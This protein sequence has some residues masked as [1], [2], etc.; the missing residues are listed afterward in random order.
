MAKVKVNHADVHSR[1]KPCIDI[2]HFAALKSRFGKEKFD[3]IVTSFRDELMKS[4]TLLNQISHEC[5]ID[6]IERQLHAIYGSAMTY[7]ATLIAKEMDCIQKALACRDR[8]LPDVR[9]LVSAI[10]VTILFINANYL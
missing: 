5:S 6:D 10:K 8:S 1:I 9:Q 3:L 4:V 2:A 7:R